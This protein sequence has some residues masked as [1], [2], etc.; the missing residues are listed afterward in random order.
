M[1]PP[2]VRLQRECARELVDMLTRIFDAFPDV[3]TILL[4]PS[5][6]LPMKRICVLLLGLSIVACNPEQKTASTDAKLAPAAN[7]TAVATPPAEALATLSFE[8]EAFEDCSPVKGETAMI[9]WDATKSGAAGVDIVI[10][11]ADGVV[12][13]FAWGGAVGEKE[14]GPWMTPGIVIVVRDKASGRELTRTVG[15]SEP[16]ND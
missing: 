10:I 11:G 16:C 12:G 4:P 2:R 14:S 9:R 1:S 6:N 8:P 7:V 15:G 13:Q 5:R 3:G